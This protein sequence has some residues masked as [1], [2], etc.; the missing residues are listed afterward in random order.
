VVRRA[1]SLQKR[2]ESTAVTALGRIVLDRK[3]PSTAGPV[4]EMG[5]L[6]GVAASKVPLEA[7]P[8]DR[9]VL[10]FGTLMPRRWV[11]ECLGMSGSNVT[12]EVAGLFRP[13]PAVLAGEGTLSTV[14]C[15]DVSGEVTL[16][17]RRVGAVGARVSHGGRAECLRV[18]RIHMRL[19]IA[20]RSRPIAA[21]GAMM[22]PLSTMDSGDV[23]IDIPLAPMLERAE[24]AGVRARWT[25]S[26]RATRRRRRARG[27]ERD[28]GL[29][30]LP[31]GFDR[32]RS[33]G[34]TH[35]GVE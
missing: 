4:A 24:G 34:R 8:L 13:V 32:L 3:E 31:W 26:R 1:P 10:A 5:A 20:L 15:V 2:L 35:F 11:I 14:H 6:G 23:L 30:R 17:G 25:R 12:S 19:E 29:P 7:A 22:F 16:L 27:R 9:G 28:I 18:S 21:V 33:L